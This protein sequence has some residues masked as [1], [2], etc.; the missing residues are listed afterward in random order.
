MTMAFPTTTG[1]MYLEYHLQKEWIVNYTALEKL[2][3]SPSQP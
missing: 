3:H 2:F 1:T